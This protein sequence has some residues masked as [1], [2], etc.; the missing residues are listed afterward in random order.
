MKKADY[1]RNRLF[2][3]NRFDV[4]RIIGENMERLTK[5]NDAILEQI[6]ANPTEFDFNEF[7]LARISD[8]S[9]EVD[10]LAGLSYYG[11]DLYNRYVGG[12][13][14]RKERSDS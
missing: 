2:E 11:D 4:D 9:G 13:L 3:I 5:E 7:L 14:F 8:N 10:Y 6:D 1:R 12:P